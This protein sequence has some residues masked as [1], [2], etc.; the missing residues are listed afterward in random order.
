VEI[1]RKMP[2]AKI[3]TNHFSKAI[4]K[5]IDVIFAGNLE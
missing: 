2:F 1:W 5:A 4:N 3:K